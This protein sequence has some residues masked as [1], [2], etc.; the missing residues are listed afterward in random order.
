MAVLKKMVDGGA[1]AAMRGVVDY[2]FWKSIPVARAWPRKAIQPGTVKQQVT[3]N[4]FRA[5][6]EFKP[7]IPTSVML[8]WRTL[9]VPANRTQ[10]DIL[11]SHYLSLAYKDALDAV[12]DILSVSVSVDPITFGQII[13]VSTIPPDNFD[14]VSLVWY[15][16]PSFTSTPLL[17]WNRAGVRVRKDKYQDQLWKPNL[18]QFE[19]VSSQSYDSVSGTHTLTP[20]T[21][22]P[23]PRIYAR[24]VFALDLPLFKIPPIK[25]TP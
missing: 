17:T 12:P 24:S 5:W 1:I 21:E 6:K 15:S 13:L 4:A 20:V 2:Y 7:T 14:P 10:Q 11:K 9:P 22:S 3:W 19:Q 16:A 8:A 18:A 23:T 25:A